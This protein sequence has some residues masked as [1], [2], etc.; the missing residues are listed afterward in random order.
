MKTCLLAFALLLCPLLFA[1]DW[2]KSFPITGKP[3]VNVRAD[4]GNVR[5]RSCDCKTVE[6]RVISDGYKPGRVKITPSQTGNRVELEVLTQNPHANFNI[7]FGG[8]HHRLDIEISLPRESDLDIHTSD[9]HI[10]AE[11][12]KGDLHLETGDGHIELRSVEGSL[13]ARSGDGHMDVS[14][15]F[16]ELTLQSG[17]GSIRA[18]VSEGSR[19][20]SSWSLQTGDG[21]ITLRL[22]KDFSAD[23]DAHTGDGRVYSDLPVT[24]DRFDSGH[25]KTVRGKLNAGGGEL[26]LRSGDGSIYLEK[27]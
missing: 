3:T 14:G 7:N 10:E 8:I 27:L 12:V 19:I 16:D 11:Q 25:D 20:G 24:M 4:D 22:P 9:G 18:E 1:E 21:K 13:R 23:L 2:T 15:R 6:A 17:D 5:I 26:R